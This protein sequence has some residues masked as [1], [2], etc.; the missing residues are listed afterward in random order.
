MRDFVLENAISFLNSPGLKDVSSLKYSGVSYRRPAYVW[1]DSVLTVHGL[2]TAGTCSR[3]MYY[4]YSLLMTDARLS[5]NYN[6]K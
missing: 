3:F 6:E 5:I 2:S 1:S 4:P